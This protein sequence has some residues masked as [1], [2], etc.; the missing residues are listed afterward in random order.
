MFSTRS[1][2]W[3]VRRIAIL[4]TIVVMGVLAA[5][6]AS[7]AQ[8]ANPTIVG[9]L[10]NFDVR[11]EMQYEA[12]GF[13]IQLEGIEIND[14]TRVFGESFAGA[15]FTRFCAPT[16][17]AFPGGVIVRWTAVFNPA[18]GNRESRLKITGTVVSPR[19]PVA[20]KPFVSGE[21]CWVL[22]L[23]EAYPASGCEHFGLSTLRNPT[24]TTYRWLVADPVDPSLLI[25]DPGGPV[26]IPAPIVEVVPVN[27]ARPELG[28]AIQQEIRG[29]PS[30]TGKQY[31]E[32]Q[33]VKVY[34]MD[35][36]R[37]VDLEE[38]MRG[39]PV[40]PNDANAE[41]DWK[42]LQ[43]NSRSGGNSGVLQS[44]ANSG[45][46]S[47]AVVRRYE[48]YH[49]AGPYDP[50]THEALC[51]DGNCV[52]PSPGELGAFIGSQM[53]AA[54][55]QAPARIALNR[56][57]V[58]AGGAVTATVSDGPAMP[59]DWMGLY[60]GADALVTSY[61]DWKYLNGSHGKPDGGVANAAV[62]FTLPETAGT[63]TLK[64]FAAG[65]YNVVATSAPITV[66]T[67]S[68]SLSA[69]TVA[70]GGT[71]TAT[72]A[73]GPGMPGDWIG[74]YDASGAL[75]SNREWQYLNRSHDKPAAGSSN[76]SVSFTMPSTPGSYNLRL[77]A[78]S[79]YTLVAT[80][81]PVTVT[82][83]GPASTIAIGAR[84]VSA[85]ATIAATIANG[86]GTPGDWIG[87][88]DTS[89]G[90]TDY[91]QWKYLNGSFS[92]P[93]A[94]L[95]G[96][97]VT[98]TAPATVGTYELRLFANSSYTLAATSAPITVAAPAVTLD[99]ETVKAGGTVTVTIAG[100]PGQPGDWI[101][102][103]D[104]SGSLVQYQQWQY[105]NGAQTKPEVGLTD[106]TVTFTAPSTPGTYNVRLFTNSS[107]VLLATSAAFI[108]P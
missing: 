95:A 103:Y 32:A 62:S 31:G 91:L 105:L 69:S 56:S 14:I 59:G 24:K 108:V 71:V 52:A 41:T 12:E 7:E 54:N 65:T 64:L 27:A 97:T 19:T 90:V 92:K 101:G 60:D 42:L 66:A 2:E 58:G 77:F 83:A 82:S 20:T 68:I 4:A 102:L 49:Y 53:A 45:S 89:S 87:L 11:N 22:G 94:G 99:S 8:L 26:A 23:A 39:N 67:P 55:L 34:K 78:N 10:S 88:F 25:P 51:A 29:L 81:A 28:K 37:K 46:S 61:R 63:Y 86:P 44:K 48:F 1:F 30:Q 47:H 100:G 6:R 36:G 104:E 40:V 84:R 21:E 93:A 33:W 98:F 16:V 35:V 57:F 72:I 5:S 38:L 9:S 13:E 80:S 15:C 3:S 79:S 50:A 107:Y 75:S 17:T 70:A 73:N 85:G 43:H 106:A 96:A 76:A 74:L 18:T